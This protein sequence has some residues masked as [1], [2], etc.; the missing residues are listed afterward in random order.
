MY[1]ETGGRGKDHPPPPKSWT[2]FQAI[3]LKLS[4]SFLRCAT[5]PSHPSHRAVSHKARRAVMLEAGYGSSGSEWDFPKHG[6]LLL[7]NSGRFLSPQNAAYGKRR[8]LANSRTL[9]QGQR[10]KEEGLFH[11]LHFPYTR[12]CVCVPLDVYSL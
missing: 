11:L 3:K 10:G 9:N 1:K 7:R 6:R 2:I 5:G 8:I 4:T 12:V